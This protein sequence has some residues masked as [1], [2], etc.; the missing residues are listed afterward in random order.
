MAGR[1][2]TRRDF[3]VRAASLSAVWPLAPRWAL[4]APPD[5]PQT[6]AVAVPRDRRG[7]FVVF[8][9][10]GF[11]VIDVPPLV[12]LPGAVAATSAADLVARLQPH[13]VLVWRHGSAFPADA[14]A[15]ISRFL[16]A[17]GSLLYLGG[18]PFTRPVTG[19][20]GARH[21]E[22]RTVAFLQHLRL[23][24]SYRV[25]VGGATLHPG[26]ALGQTDRSL[27]PD[28]WASVLEPRLSDTIDFPSESGSPGQRDAV[29]RPLAEVVAPGADP[30]FPAAA[31]A[32]VIDRLLGRF[33]KGRWV[34]WLLS[35]APTEGE[36]TALLSEATRPPFDLRLDP[37]FGCFHAGERASAIVRVH[38]PGAD[39]AIAAAGTIALDGPGPAHDPIPVRLDVAEHGTARVVFP[40]DLRP[41]LHRATIDLP[42]LGRTVTGFWVF[43]AELFASGD[44][45]SFDG[46]T[47]RRN[48]RPEPVVGTTVM[49]ATVHR[50]FLFEPN[51]AVW[52][53]T[54]AEIAS[55]GINLVR[56]GLW[57][58]WR[59]ISLEAGEVDEGVVR[60]LEAY[61][62]T[63]R[64]HG[65]P[66]LFNA[67]AF[68]PEAFGGSDPYLD[69][70]ALEGQR[71]LLSALARRMAPARE[72]LWDLINEPSFAS[73]DRLWSLRP[74]GS[75][76]ERRAFLGWLRERYGAN[77]SAE[78]S[79]W[80]D[81]VRRRWR[82]RPDEAIGLPGDRDFQDAYVP[83][84]RR[85]YRALDYALFAQDA[86]EGWIRAMRSA[87]HDGG[88]TT[89]VTVGQDEAGLSRSPSPLFFH[90][91]VDFASMHTWWNN[92]AL[93][94]DGVLAKPS[95]A[96]LLVSET[97]IM[98]HELLSG[99]AVRDPQ[100]F[101]NLLSRKLAYAFAAGA[102]GVVEWVYDVNPYIA[103]DNEAAI[104][105]RRVDG[106]FKPEH[107]VLADLAR[108]VG[109]HRARFD[110]Y[111]EPDVVL[112]VPTADL[113]SSRDTATRAT[114][115]AVRACYETIGVRVRAVPD[116]RAARDL[117]D[118]RLVILPACRGVS[119]AGWAAVL[120][121]VDAGATLACSGWF[122]TDD[123][124]LPAVRLGVERRPLRIVEDV[125]DGQG[126]R[127]SYRFS[128]PLDESWYAAKGAAPS[129]S[130]RGR[131]AI[132]HHPLPLE[133]AD[134]TPGLAAFYRTALA[135]ASITPNAVFDTGGPGLVAVIVPFRSDWLL[136]AVNETSAARR[137][138][139]SRP[140]AS[141]RFSL[142]VPAARSRLAVVDPRRWTVLDTDPA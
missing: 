44:R 99:E 75:P 48:G 118:P 35:V 23:N 110:G 6:G 119:D 114:R 28:A 20:P 126:R 40:A 81:V 41:G 77:G 130:A 59:K 112:L 117:G 140:G 128:S 50:D 76:A 89:P 58:G 54:F 68:T 111:V 51:A 138:Q 4:A 10:P 31:A 78:N 136:V 107:G 16:E 24:Q 56:T 60:A 96:P 102:F 134:P 63:A 12:T 131:G 95:G 14:W 74:S 61:Y 3:L 125:A 55:L 22:P 142:D 121:A 66:V 84:P 70:R 73:P 15:G 103:N 132:L 113:L 17:G 36:L 122:E 141:A 92:D 46:F 33:A 87:L 47:L 88:S 137:L 32:Y 5:R 69:P 86:F 124:G 91:A 100:E 108:F 129:R 90:D 133:W 13:A 19:A 83:G 2:V 85:P 27:P 42:A 115:A 79:A 120:A 37:T 105:L 67:F 97:G 8:D 9:E 123:A 1:H 38:R 139:V 98:Q 11:P 18:E 80:E 53:D 39:D 21:V 45:L 57:S 52:D 135:S 72:L 127:E 106:S 101:A 30:R 94:W 7:P 34:L 62:L 71:A 26:A 104:G 116:H 43:D 82:L 64:A 65:V 93:V 49:S 25:P 29:V 109:R